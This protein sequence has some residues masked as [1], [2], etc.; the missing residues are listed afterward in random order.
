M[1]AAAGLV[2]AGLLWSV[3]TLRVTTPRQ[4]RR[5]ERRIDDFEQLTALREETARYRRALKTYEELPEPRLAPLT[6]IAR[7]TLPGENP[8]VRRV[9]TRD[10]ARGWVL[11]RVEVRL[12]NIAFAKAGTLIY[13]AVPLADS[14][15]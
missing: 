6:R 9:E 7:E 4:R 11:R 5:I 15:A 3:Y 8:V 2:A 13:A 1:I 12:E 14:M 10:A